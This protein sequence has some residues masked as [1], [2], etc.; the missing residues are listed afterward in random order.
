MNSF[1]IEGLR[2]R[3]EAAAGEASGG[4]ARRYCVAFSGGLDSTVLLVAMQRLAAR[5]AFDGLRAIHVHHGLHA[6]ADRWAEAC[7]AR[8]R[9]LGVPLEVAEVDARAAPGESPEARARELR[10]RAL[11]ERLAPGEVLLTAQHADDQLETVLIQL[12]RG[13]G[14]AGLAAMP[15]DTAFGAGRHQRPLLGFTRASLAA[16]A[17]A[18]GLADWVEDP[19]NR[20]PQ[21]SRNHLRHEVLPAVRT[22]WP[23][24]AAAVSRAARHCAEAAGL[25][26]ELAA[27]D[28]AACVDGEALSLAA[29]RALSPA[30]RR[31]L[32][33]WQCRCLGLPVPDE[34]RLGTLLEQL[35]DAA[36]DRHPEVRWPGVS[37]QRHADRLWL[38]PESALQPVPAALDW[39][40][41]RVPLELGA[42]L[43]RLSLQPSQPGGGLRAEA[44]AAGPWR[45]AF[46]AGGERLE[47]PGRSGSRALKKLMNE[48]GVPPW[49]RP[50][51]P[52]VEI[53]GTLAAVGDLWVA[54]AWSAP[55]EHKGWRVAWEGCA[56]PG[57]R[58]VHCGR[59]GLLIV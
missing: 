59:A 11:A 57:G 38:L 26:D 32:V 36:G 50:R 35:F 33:R 29:M 51:M 13:A 30:R 23:G 44:L 1:G 20:A 54:V 52:L 5:G 43:G 55:P 12:L 7:E 19:A 34:R 4:E 24:A 47:L 25:L 27:L 49:L 10:Y 6:D 16:W 56:L 9:D 14:P 3:L 53:G 45:V 58:G 42:G 48:A 37:A 17:R 18:E 41:P 8:C 46:R 39:P 28:A 2:Q 31:N 22:H 40:D 21:F 15:A